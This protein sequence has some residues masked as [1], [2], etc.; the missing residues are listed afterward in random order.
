LRE[1]NTEFVQQI[2]VE[3]FMLS[4]RDALAG[5]AALLLPSRLRGRGKQCV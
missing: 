2:I 1:Q 4:R 3:G 5:M